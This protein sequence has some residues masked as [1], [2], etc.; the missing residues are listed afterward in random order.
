MAVISTTPNAI[1]R[2]LHRVVLDADPDEFK[3]FAALARHIAQNKAGEFSYLRFGQLV[4]AGAEAIET[5]VSFAHD[6]GLLDGDLR[7]TRPKKEIRALENFQ[8]WL[9]DLTMQYLKAR[10]ASLKQIELAIRD[11]TQNSPCRLPT[12]ENI[13]TKL[14]ESAFAAKLQIRAQ[15]R[16]LVAKQCDEPCLAPPGPNGRDCGKLTRSVYVIP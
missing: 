5:Y 7:T 1:D 14:E 9:S 10:A 15:D 3:S 6:I 2:K 4:Y 8:Q 12:Q 13:R 11:L 16:C